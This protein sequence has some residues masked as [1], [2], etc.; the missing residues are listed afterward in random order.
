MIYNNTNPVPDPNAIVDPSTVV[1]PNAPVGT[2][3]GSNGKVL[4]AVTTG[5]NGVITKTANQVPAHLNAANTLM[6]TNNIV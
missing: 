6:T 2:V 1:D 4:S 3:G 5:G